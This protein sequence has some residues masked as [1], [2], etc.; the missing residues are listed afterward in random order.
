MTPLE[1]LRQEGGFTL[2]ELLMVL[3]I[4]ALVTAVSVPMMRRQSPAQDLAAASIELGSSLKLARAA[5]RTG[6][7]EQALMLSLDR[8]VYWSDGVLPPRPFARTLEVVLDAPDSER[9]DSATGR[10]RFF[11]DGTATPARVLLRIGK[12]ETALAVNWLTGEIRSGGP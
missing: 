2:I 3:G 6:N 11:A 10:I 1:R 12:L 5:A 7:T 4:I 8:R 9:L